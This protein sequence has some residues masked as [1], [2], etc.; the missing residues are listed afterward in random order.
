MVKISIIYITAR[1]NYPISS[2]PGVH[3][4]TLFL[5]SLKKQTFKNFEVIISDAWY[6]ERNKQNKQ[7]IYDFSLYPFVIKYVNPYEIS[8]AKKKGLL[9]ISD[10]YNMGVI[11]SD[12]EL[13]L[14]FNDCC[15]LVNNNTLQ[16][17]WDE[18]QKGYFAS[19]LVKYYKNN[20][21]WYREN[22]T[23]VVDS[24]WEYLEKEKER[25]EKEIKRLK[26]PNEKEIK[27]ELSENGET[28]EIEL[29]REEKDNIIKD[30]EIK[31]GKY[32]FPGSQ[33]YGYASSSLEATLIANGYDANFDGQ[34]SLNDVEFGVRLERLGYKFVCNE[35]L[36]LVEH[37]HDIDLPKEITEGSPKWSFRCNLGLI[38]LHHINNKNTANDYKL[39]VADLVHIIEQG[40]KL[41]VIVLPRSFEY[42]VLMYW[43]NNPPIFNLREL[44]NERLRKEGKYIDK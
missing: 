37:V 44:R 14:W 33:Y 3:Q 23:S 11:Y 13:L 41:G 16:L 38:T 1:V 32:Y 34:K 22:G 12:G 30:L 39:S 4:F 10:N 20:K 28:V 19:V 6:D 24:R 36:W 17:L 8:W 26:D 27:I 9:C 15:E 2:L 21:Q 7:G 18:Y 35:N 25:L 5:D 31:V 42:K 29:N 40:E 43:F